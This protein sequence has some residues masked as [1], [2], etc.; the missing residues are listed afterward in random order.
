MA[1][2]NVRESLKGEQVWVKKY[3]YVLRPL[4]AICWIERDLGRMP[5]EF[6]VLLEQTVDDPTLL[7]AITDVLA[8]KRAGAK[9][10]KRPSIP[11]ISDF[12]DHELSRLSARTAEVPVQRCPVD[13]FNT[14]F[15][16]ALDTIWAE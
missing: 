11:V 2:G 12:I 3:F 14:V 16:H 13:A 8:T 7:Q 15:R 9:L 1:Q 10:D 6:A 5:T 4:L